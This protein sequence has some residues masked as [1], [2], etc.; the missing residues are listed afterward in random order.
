MRTLTLCEI[1]QVSG[2]AMDPSEFDA[3]CFGIFNGAVI[4]ATTYAML[5]GKGSS[6]AGLLTFGVAQLVGVGLGILIGGVNGAIYGATHTAAESEAYFT[7]IAKDAGK[8]W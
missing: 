4:G 5:G 8:L 1:N 6:V 7:N 3:I 2:A